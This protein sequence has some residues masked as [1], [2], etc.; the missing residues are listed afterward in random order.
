M[1]FVFRFNSFFQTKEVVVND[2]HDMIINLY[3]EILQ[4][5]LKRDYISKT[6]LDELNPKNG[7]YELVNNQLYL[8]ISV[9]RY[10]DRPEIV[11]DQHRLKDFYEKY[12]IKLNF[13]VYYLN[14]FF[15]FK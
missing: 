10:K 1:H 3:T 9:M 14:L 2:L 13:F 15:F 11:K 12:Y 8:G 5:F 6:P 7:Q 4:C